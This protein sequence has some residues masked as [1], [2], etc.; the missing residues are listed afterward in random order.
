MK[1]ENIIDALNNIIKER[2]QFEGI[3]DSSFLVLHRSVIPHKTFKAYKGVTYTLY[4]VYG[5]KYEHKYKLVC[6]PMQ[7]KASDSELDSKLVEYETKFVETLFNFVQ[8]NE[9]L[10]AVKGKYEI[11]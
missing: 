10:N 1:I 8:S 2:R 11:V 4:L 3:D 9:F 7:I 5:G 6:L